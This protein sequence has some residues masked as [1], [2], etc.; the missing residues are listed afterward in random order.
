MGVAEGVFQL[1][2]LY[3]CL[4]GGELVSGGLVAK[5]ICL[6]TTQVLPEYVDAEVSLYLTQ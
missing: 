5:S 6:M 2:N 1:I 3:G 4:L